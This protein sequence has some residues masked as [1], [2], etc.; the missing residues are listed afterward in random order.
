MADT[1]GT[2]SEPSPGE[3]AGIIGSVASPSPATTVNDAPTATTS[4]SV[5]IEHHSE[6]DHSPVPLAHL[7]NAVAPSKSKEARL[8]AEGKH[9]G[10]P[11]RFHG[12]QRAMLESLLEKYHAVPKGW[13]GRNPFLAEFWTKV[14]ALFW[15]TFSWK[16]VRAGMS[17]EFETASME[18]VVKSTNEVSDFNLP[19]G[20]FADWPQS[21]MSWFRWRDRSL[22]AGKTNPWE[23]RLRELRGYTAKNPRRTASWQ[24][25]HSKFP[26]MMKEAL[27]MELGDV[28]PTLADR[29]RVAQKVFDGLDEDVQKSL[30]EET[31]EALRLKKEGLAQAKSKSATALSPEEQE[32]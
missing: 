30:M 27:L 11:G 10:N 3:E 12:E 13:K 24:L 6:G 29:N 31:E 4:G 9:A 16:D 15:E 32:E 5:D 25:V 28:E 23:K 8:A 22:G 21:I 2:R 19:Y 7:I 20:S 1:P 14:R 17:K 18:V 26:E